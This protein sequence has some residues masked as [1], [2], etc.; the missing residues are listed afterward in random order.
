MVLTFDQNLETTSRTAARQFG[1]KFGGG[2]LQNATCD[3]N[4]WERGDAHSA[5]GESGRQVVT[6]SYTKPTR[7]PLKGTNDEEVV[8]ISDQ[9]VTVNTGPA[10]GSLPEGSEKG[11]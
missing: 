8:A 2:A 3:L 4:Q 7:N 10:Y 5:G 6:V 9:D 1:I 11:A